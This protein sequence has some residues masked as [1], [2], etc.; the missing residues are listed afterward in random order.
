MPDTW[1]SLSGTNVQLT[2]EYSLVGLIQIGY[3]DLRLGEP[4]N[5]NACQGCHD[6]DCMGEPI[7]ERERGLIY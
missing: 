6:F 3:D 4:L 2:P 5:Y 1:Y 7:I